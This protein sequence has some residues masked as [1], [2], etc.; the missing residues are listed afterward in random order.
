MF[1]YSNNRVPFFSIILATY[2]RAYV[3]E[4]ALN[5]VLNQKEKDWELLIIDDGSQDDTYKVCS[6][7]F[8]DS[9][10]RYFF[11]TNRGLALSRNVGILSSAGVYL[12][13]LDSD[14]EYKDNHLYFRKQILMQNPDVDLLY[15]AVEIIGNPYV[16]DFFDRTKL[17][18]IDNC[19]VGGTFFIKKEVALK[20]NGFRNIPYGDDFDFATR[21]T[22]EGFTVASVEY[23]TYIYHRDLADSI[24]NNF[25][26]ITEVK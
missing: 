16:P 19:Y 3:L 9:R 12:T 7:Y 17:I 4:R 15:G 8:G 5:S 24:C 13:F 23:K 10:I 2:N 25:L 18:H 11:H 22:S 26:N 21:A 6:K 20:L 1:I 14:D